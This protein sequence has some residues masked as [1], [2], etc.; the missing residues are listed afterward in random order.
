[1]PSSGNLNNKIAFGAFQEGELKSENIFKKQSFV[2][3]GPG[4]FGLGLLWKLKNILQVP[5]SDFH[6]ALAQGSEEDQEGRGAQ[7]QKNIRGLPHVLHR[8]DLGKEKQV[9]WY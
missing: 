6:D 5:S 3:R 1:M 8:R 9:S 7:V 2:E 4:A